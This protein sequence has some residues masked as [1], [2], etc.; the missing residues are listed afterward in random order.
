MQSAH[1][2][3]FASSRGV[4]FGRY[5]RAPEDFGERLI[6]NDERNIL[7]FGPNGCGKGTR[8][9]MPNLLQMQDCSLVVV[10][11][12]GELAAVTAPYRR[13]VG[14]VVIINPFGV[15]TDIPGYEDLKSAGFN[16]LRALDPR[17]PSFNADASWLAEALITI[18]GGEPHWPRSARKLISAL[19]MYV[20]LELGEKA[21]LGDVRRLLTEPSVEPS[22][23]H[24]EGLGLVNTARKMYAA[25]LP[26]RDLTLRMKAGQFM[27]VNR[28]IQSI[29]STADTQTEALD[30]AE[31]AGD[32]A[33]PGINF[34]D[35]KKRPITVYLILPPDMMERHGRWLRLVISSALRAVMRRR[36]KNDMRVYFLM[37]EFAALGHLS[38]IETTWALV[39]GYGI[40]LVP[41]L[42]D[43]NQL[44]ELYRDRWQTFIG[45]AGVTAAFGPNDLETADWLSRRS[46]DT[47]ETVIGYNESSGTGTSSTGVNY[48]QIKVPRLTPHELFDTPEGEAHIW[49][50]GMANRVPA[51]MPAWYEISQCRERVTRDN[52][53]YAG[54]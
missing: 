31:I 23:E 53:Y 51:Y 8:F 13:E 11:P 28:E 32:L 47:T 14:E 30:D 46:G 1:P 40:Q 15:L 10:D 27:Q 5:L 21:T 42:Q 12:K 2:P 38:I 24:P 36:E 29:V 18:E 39:R 4:S 25:Q 45:M 33:K 44:K 20:C 37:D 3:A 22:K 9:L 34:R 26:R 52:P 6:Y 43:L 54:G 49:L 41:V 16:P 19:I 50:A 7:L 35:L 17:L 48:Q